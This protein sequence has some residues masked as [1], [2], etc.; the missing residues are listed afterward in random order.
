[1]LSDQPSTVCPPLV[2]VFLRQST[3]ACTTPSS[4]ASSG[5]SEVSP[6]TRKCRLALIHRVAL[7]ALIATA[8][9]ALAENSGGM[10]M[11]WVL[12]SWNVC[13]STSQPHDVVALN[14]WNVPSPMK[15]YVCSSKVVT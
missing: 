8:V 1:M 10:P 9:T 11:S 13:T 15:S 2:A 14:S 3:P 12:D 6:T 7:P 4:P 5:V